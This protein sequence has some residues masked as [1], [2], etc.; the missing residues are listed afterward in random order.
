MATYKA[1]T[2]Y[3]DETYA[4]AYFGERLGADNYEN[5]DSA[6]R[7]KALKQATRQIDLLPLIGV[8]YDDTQDREFPRNFDGATV[9]EEVMDA[10]CEVALAILSGIYG[11]AKLGTV[12][13]NS[14]N[15]GDASVSYVGDRGEMSVLDETFGLGSQEAAQMLAPWLE[16]TNVIDITRV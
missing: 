14:E 13:V 10:C 5:A 1:I 12:G 4:T 16:D 15:T 3:A 7:L 9:P 2:P 11:S 8:K 6:T